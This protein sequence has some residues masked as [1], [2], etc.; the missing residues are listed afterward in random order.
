MIN[1]CETTSRRCLVALCFYTSFSVK[2]GSTGIAT[3]CATYM[4]IPTRRI[5]SLMGFLSLF[6]LTCLTKSQ[7]TAQSQRIFYRVL[8]I[9]HISMVDCLL[10]MILT[11]AHVYSPKNILKDYSASSIVI[12]SQSTKMTPKMQKSVLTRK[13][14][15]V[16]SRT[17]LKITRIR[18]PSTHRKRLWSICAVSQS[19]RISKTINSLKR[20]MNVYESLLKRKTWSFSMSVNE[21]RLKKVSLK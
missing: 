16:S 7:K 18:E 4:P 17:F 13:C 19:S 8:R 2:V 14:S 5:I 6:S 11:N 15:V 21:M 9:S 1:L 20:E 12:T 10:K 3:I